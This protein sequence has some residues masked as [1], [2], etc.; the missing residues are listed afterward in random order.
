MIRLRT[1]E[2]TTF[3]VLCWAHHI[4]PSASICPW[5]SCCHCLL[6]EQTWWAAWPISLASGY[7]QFWPM[8]NTSK[9]SKDTGRWGQESGEGELLPVKCILPTGARS[10]CQVPIP[11]ASFARSPYLFPCLYLQATGSNCCPLLLQSDSLF[12]VGWPQPFPHLCKQPQFRYA[13]GFLLGR[14]I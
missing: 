1:C 5:R 6:W 11:I 8:G 2:F 10:S 7:G 13:I 12:L 9:R 3:Q 14:T 4:L